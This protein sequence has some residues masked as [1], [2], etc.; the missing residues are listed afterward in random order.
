MT[1]PIEVRDMRIVHLAFRKAYDETARL[2]RVGPMT[3]PNRVEFLADHVDFA[4]ALLHAH[5]ESEDESE[6]S[7][8]FEEHHRRNRE[9]LT[10]VQRERFE[11]LTERFRKKIVATF[12]N[13]VEFETLN[14]QTRI[15]RSKLL[16]N[17]P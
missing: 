17:I 2:L 10:Q 7:E 15:V 1:P 4:I 14:A 9:E 5:H 6:G 13:T 8:E 3:S 16:Q 12:G 11:N